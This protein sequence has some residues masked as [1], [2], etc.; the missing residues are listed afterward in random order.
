MVHLD[1]AAFLRPIAH[2][3]W[4]NNEAGRTENSRPAFAAAIGQGY[5]IECDLRP[6]KDGLPVVFHDE[7]L[8]RITETTEVNR[9]RER[10]GAW[11][12]FQRLPTP[13]GATDSVQD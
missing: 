7:T 1:R 11:R 12:A 13:K 9:I 5:G 4:H 3:G 8:D 10:G 2:R 6:A